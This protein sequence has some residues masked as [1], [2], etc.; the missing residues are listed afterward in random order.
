MIFDD[1]IARFAAY[2]LTAGGR[3]QATVDNYSRDLEQFAALS[4]TGSLSAL[5]RKAV[6]RWLNGLSELELAPRSRSRKLSAL[7]SFVGWLIEYGYLEENPIPPDIGSPQA[8][9]LPHALTEG[10]IEAMLHA[11]EGD[12]PV[13][14]RDRAIMETLYASGMRVSELTGL[15]L[16][17]LQLDEGFTIVTGKG[18][19]QRLVPLG[20]YAIESIQLYLGKARGLLCQRAAQYGEVFLTKRGPIS[21]AT[22]F[23]IVK[24]YAVAAKVK[25][26]VSPHTFR[27]SCASHLLAHG[28]D[29]RLVQ[30]LLGH[31]SLSTTQIYTHIEKSRLRKVYDQTHPMA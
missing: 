24:K 19:K 11:A 15:Q 29:L 27:H 22:V 3:S 5:D 13:T 4:K 25:S 30:E 20:G 12:E 31:A 7:R 21:R 8:L 18:N 14:M 6:L 28:A 26:N 23:R 2:Q 9:Q 1:A 16:L 17:D 10:E